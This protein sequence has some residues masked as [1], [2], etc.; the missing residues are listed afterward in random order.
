MESFFEQVLPEEQQ[1]VLIFH[2]FLCFILYRV[3]NFAQLCGFIPVGALK[4]FSQF[5][6]RLFLFHYSGLI[7]VGHSALFYVDST[8]LGEKSPLC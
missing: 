8:K 2:R 1:Y 5:H 7:R 4:E 3:K 6:T